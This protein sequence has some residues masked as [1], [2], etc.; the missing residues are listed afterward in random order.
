MAF[1]SRVQLEAIGFASLGDNVLISDAARIYNAGGISLCSNVRIDDFCILSAGR[2]GIH[3]GMHVHIG[4]FASL[5]GKETITLRDFAGLSAR[6][7]IFSSSDDYS[8]GF[9]TNPTVPE[10]YRQVEH[11]A[12]D[13]GRHAIIGAGSVILPGVTVGEGASTGALTLVARDLEP[14]VSYI[15]VPARKTGERKRD[16]LALERQWKPQKPD[17]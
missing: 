8:G 12:V 17:R 10:R 7:S 11:G 4:C 16:L 2:G 1:L 5:I 15:G 9:L 3:I 6:V 13:I 14:F